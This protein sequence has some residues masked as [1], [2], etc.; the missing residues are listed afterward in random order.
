MTTHLLMKGAAV[1]A[2]VLTG[3]LFTAN[4]QDNSDEA[5]VETDRRLGII[6]VTSTK[7]EESLQDVPIAVTALSGETLRDAGI[8]SVQNI[9]AVAPSVTFTQSSNDQNNSV[10]IRGIGTSVF[11]QGVESSVSIVLDDVVLA[12]QGIGFQ[13]LVDVEQVEVLR[14][15]QSTLFG[16]NA[17]AGVISVTTA[18]PEQ[19]FGGRIDLSAAE[20]GE[21]GFGATLTG[22]LTETLSA[23][24]TAY[25]KQ[26][27]GHISNADGQDLNG[28]ENWG[29]RGKLLFEPTSNFDV[30]LIADY[31][32]SQQNCCIYTVRDVSG[33]VGAAQGLAGLLAP[34]V[35]GSENADSNVNAPV[36]NNSDQWGL[37]AK[38]EYEFGNGFT[39]TSITAYRDFDFI[40]NIDVDNLPFADPQL[41]FITFN[42]NSGATRFKALTQ[43]LRLTSP[44]SDRFDYVVGAFGY[45]SLVDRFFQRRF[46]ILI[47][48]GGGNTFQ[49]NQSGQIVG[50]ADTTNL[51]VFG[52]ANFHVTDN[53]TIFGGLRLL[54]EKL[55][56]SALRD[57]TNVLQPGDRPFG[58]DPGTPL[59][60]D[61]DTSDTAL[62]GEIGIRHS[63]TDDIQG[64]LRFARGYKG[65]AID[66]TFGAATNVEPIEAEESDAYEAGLKSTLLDERATLNLALFHT[67]FS[68]FQEQ[69]TVLTAN[70]NDILNAEVLLTNV[71]SVETTGA[72]LDFLFAPTDLTTIQGGIA[73]IEADISSFENAS[74]FFGQTVAQGCVPVTLNDNGTPNDPTDD[75][76]VDLQD[77]S[78]ER[79]PNAPRLRLSGMIRQSIPLE[80]SFDAFAQ[81]TARYQSD[82]LFSLNND[83]RSEQEGFG[84]VNLSAGL[85]DDDGRWT[86]TVFVNNVFNQFYSTN[87][88][89]DP[90]Y[91]GVVSHYVPRDHERFFGARL[92]ANF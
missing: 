52:S 62:T 76:V 61:D 9:E 51:A 32:D 88:F 64:Y 82:T 42:L 28:Y 75:T 37:S 36:F 1:T 15:P 78:G 71:G 63:F 74:C 4:A 34:V 35:P 21:Y 67:K 87:I 5:A 48:V 60:L 53:T 16:K 19:E 38:A 30:E 90:L 55:E 69:A 50:E 43:E 13:D 47:P 17:S 2:F 31:R 18:S 73:Y 3:C 84:I 59:N 54:N 29:L 77:L 20:G 58:G 12:R 56:Y 7:R 26:F 85:E 40:N 22:G 23:R 92:T 33:A 66:N 83:P 25:Y 80:A 89:G 91:G 86:A 6:T 10:N 79:L 70:A 24:L 27:D 49:I 45:Q 11:S 81:V 72:E 57:P 39:L 14:G 65:R 44:T 68:N 8:G 41:G 46:Q